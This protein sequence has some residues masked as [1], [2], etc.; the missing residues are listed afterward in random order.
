[1]AAYM[2]E[3]RRIEVNQAVH[4]YQ[5][6]H[7]LLCSSTLVD[8]KDSKTMVIMS[9]ASGPGSTIPDSG[10]ITG[11]PLAN[12]GIYAFARTWAATEKNRPGCVWTHTLLID[13][14]KIW[15]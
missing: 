2:T 11:Y 4:G 8:Q 15:L 7:R 5:E 14:G 10:Y 12:S 9:D 3:G 1:M 13:F 6:G